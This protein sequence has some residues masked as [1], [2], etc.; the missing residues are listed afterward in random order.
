V[1]CYICGK[2]LFTGDALG[3]EDYVCVCVECLTWMEK[4]EARQVK[5]VTQLTEELRLE[6]K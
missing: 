3:V 5:R 1:D 4:D 2:L 6:R